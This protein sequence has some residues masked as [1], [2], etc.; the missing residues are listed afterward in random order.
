M[1]FC[2]PSHG[3][4]DCPLCYTTAPISFDQTREARD[5]WRITANPLAWGNPNAE[6]VVLGFSKGPTQAGALERVPHDKIAYKGSRKVV[7]KILAHVG[8]LPQTAPDCLSAAVDRLIADQNGR[9][10]FGSLIRCTVERYDANSGDW[11]GSG[12]GMLDKFVA[13]AF[14]GDVASRCASRFLGKL[15][16]TVKLIV[17][18]GLGTKGNYI[19][20]SRKLFQNARPGTWVAINEVAYSDGK[21]TVVHV[22]HF[23][24]LGALIPNWLG[25]NK[26]PRARLGVLAQEAV[27]MALK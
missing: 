20:A 5:G 2:L 11:K 17:M 12:G 15:P 4:I 18:F 6:I 25:E 14:G 3:R 1:S 27:S 21:I 19:A 9:F 10:H 16:P 13:T 7:G 8:L 22:E 26:H 23:A 24:S